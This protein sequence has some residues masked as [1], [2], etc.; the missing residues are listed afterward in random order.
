M[1]NLT[2]HGNPAF[3]MHLQSVRVRKFERPTPNPQILERIEPTESRS[4]Q[5]SK[6][7]CR[8]AEAVSLRAVRAIWRLPE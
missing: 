3:F 8:T 1:S 2:N 7:P 5:E 6:K 4:Y